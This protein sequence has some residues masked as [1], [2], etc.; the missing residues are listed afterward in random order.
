MKEESTL[1]FLRFPLPEVVEG[2]MGLTLPAAG[3]SEWLKTEKPGYVREY[4]KMLCLQEKLREGSL[5]S[6]L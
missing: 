4:L 5:S 1:S 6:T 3:H 2:E